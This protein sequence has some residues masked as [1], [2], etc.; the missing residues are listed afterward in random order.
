MP[1]NELEFYPFTSK[2][3][4]GLAKLFESSGV[5]SLF[6]SH[7]FVRG[8]SFCVIFSVKNDD[9]VRWRN[10]AVRSFKMT[11]TLVPAG[12][13]TGFWKRTVACMIQSCR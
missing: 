3:I 8:G 10:S 2:I 1:N 13:R 12:R 7:V 5:D 4:N 9:A 11:K 6:L